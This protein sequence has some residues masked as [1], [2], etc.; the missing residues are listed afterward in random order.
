[1]SRVVSSV[2]LLFSKVL[3]ESTEP[4]VLAACVR[5]PNTGVGAGTYRLSVS[6]AQF[7]GLHSTVIS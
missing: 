4:S 3:S 7:S 2:V 1:M 5:V 6:P